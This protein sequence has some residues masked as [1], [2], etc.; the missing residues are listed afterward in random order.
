MSD[1]IEIV[2][3]GPYFLV[4]GFLT[5]FL[6]GRGS[7]ARIVFNKEEH[8]ATEGITE[9]IMELVGLHGDVVHV[10]VPVATRDLLL[11][12]MKKH[13]NDWGISVK[14]ESRVSEA[15]FDFEFKVYGT[16]YAKEIKELF[17]NPPE[18]V[19]ISGYSPKEEINEDA[20]G[21]E[22]YA[23][24]HHYIFSGRGSVSGSFI[25]VLKMFRTAR[26]NPLISVDLLKI[27]R[28]G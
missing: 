19:T 17:D 9:K 28:I 21:L 12:A 4:K 14:G 13:E 15:S 22:A 18:G 10:I 16:E 26:D 27:D 20:E 7:T 25:E 3:Y 23:P 6:E 11:D 24:M 2:V 1:Y 8:I 5:G